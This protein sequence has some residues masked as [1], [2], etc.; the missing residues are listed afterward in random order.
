MGSSKDKSEAED[1]IFEHTLRNLS[2]VSWITVLVDCI[3]YIL[4]ISLVK[5]GTRSCENWATVHT[6]PSG[7]HRTIGKYPASQLLGNLTYYEQ[8]K[9][10]RSWRSKEIQCNDRL[11]AH[12][13]LHPGFSRVMMLKDRFSIRGLNGNHDCLAY[14]VLGPSIARVREDSAG[15]ETITYLTLSCAIK[16][17]HQ[18]LLGLDCMH[19]VGLVHGDIYASNVLFAVKDLSQEFLDT[20]RQP[21]DQVSVDVKRI[22]GPRQS[23]D[24]RYLTLN[25]PLNRCISTDGNVKLADLENSK[26]HPLRE[27]IHSILTD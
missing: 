11:R 16:I 15:F 14:E 20:L 24:P 19:S 25:R 12:A 8:V 5:G 7:S 22:S 13:C 27:C 17:V 10:T 26:Q 18:V 23:G 9:T 6:R 1:N 2:N 21:Y 4:V 3:L